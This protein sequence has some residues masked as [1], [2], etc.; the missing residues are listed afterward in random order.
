MRPSLRSL[1]L[2]LLL[3]AA[4]LAIGGQ[5][6]AA[7]LEADHPTFGV[8]SLTRDTSSGLDWLDLTLSTNRS[9][10]D[11]ASQ[12]GA[13]GDFEGFRHA[14]LGEVLGLWDAA[15]ITADT[16]PSA[17]LFAPVDALQGLVGVTWPDLLRSYGISG[18]EGGSAGPPEDCG[19]V[20]FT[21]YVTPAL[22]S[23]DGQGSAWTHENLRDYIAESTYGHWLVKPIPLPAALPLMGTGLAVLG[24]LGWHRRKA[25]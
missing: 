20:P 6:K 18:T 8:G 4:A 12:F 3:I 23:L 11:V 2:A 15:G 24:F 1:A 25:A 14:T 21:C 16:G 9:Y 7:I 19:G 5:V 10:A 22:S 17:A 13:G